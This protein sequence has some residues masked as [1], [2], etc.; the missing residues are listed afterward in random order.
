VDVRV[1]Q[2]SVGESA[3]EIGLEA[4]GQPV[5]I[6]L[7]WL[8]AHHAY[9]VAA[10]LA[11][12]RELGISLEEARHGMGAVQAERS[13]IKV[14]HLRDITLLEDV[15][16]SSPMSAKAALDVLAS[17]TGRR[18]AVLGDM[19]E[20]GQE[21]ISGHRDVGTYALGRADVVLAVGSR[22]HHVFEAAHQAGVEA[23]WQPTRE[24]AAEWLLA[25]L[26]AGDVVLLKA[27]RGMEFEWLTGR[28]QDARTTP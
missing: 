22:A 9:N 26:R 6:R 25:N 15:Y 10:A 24:T 4:F 3:T 16:N 27:S 17:R 19:S 28:I 18:L 21:E 23:Y 2:A 8:G 11:V 5:T 12:G 20:L 13:R 14:L 1:T 7:P